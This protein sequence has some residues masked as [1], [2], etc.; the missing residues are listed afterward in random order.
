M[1]I[2][3]ENQRKNITTTGNIIKKEKIPYKIKQFRNKETFILEPEIAV[4][5]YNKRT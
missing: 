4:L 5:I 1:S 2:T 3:T